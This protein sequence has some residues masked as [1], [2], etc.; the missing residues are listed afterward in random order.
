MENQ[1]L[2]RLNPP[3]RKSQAK[4]KKKGK[5]TPIQKVVSKKEE[6]QQRTKTETAP[7]DA[8]APRE[9]SFAVV[10]R[11][12]EKGKAALASSSPTSSSKSGGNKAANKSLT[13]P[14]QK[15]RK[16]KPP[17]TAAIVITCQDGAYEGKLK[18]ARNKVNLAELGIDSMKPKRAITGGYMFEVAGEDKSAKA[19][20]LAAKLREV[21]GGEGVKITRPRKTVELRLKGLDASI[22]PSEA[23]EALV[24]K[25]QCNLEE[26]QVGVIRRV[27]GGLGTMWAKCPLIPANRVAET[28]KI[29]ILWSMV[30][31]E[32]L[33]DRSLQ[34]FKCL[35]GG[36]VAIRCPNNIDRNNKCYRCGETG[37]RA[38]GCTN[39]VHCLLCAEYKLPT[40]HKVGS[41][42]CQAAKRKR[43]GVKESTTP[44]SSSPTPTKKEVRPPPTP[45]E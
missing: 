9:E 7:K 20:K 37:H 1:L 2:L 43:R 44:S 32:I 27:P 33:A 38:Q 10:T 13:S 29:Q 34:C 21:I 5:K 17:N 31:A 24:W 12:R 6:T 30:R 19:D 40:R 8:V 11:R 3:T 26:I 39:E 4:K 14:Q 25:G 36:H 35:E 28:G 15:A 22:T 23:R 45:M 16:R 42:A 18:E 41:K